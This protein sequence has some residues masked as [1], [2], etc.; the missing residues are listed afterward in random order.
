MS[1]F[2]WTTL[3]YG[4]YSANFVHTWFLASFI[5]KWPLDTRKKW[6][7]LTIK[8]LTWWLL[9]FLFLVKVP[10]F[11]KLEILLGKWKSGLEVNPLD[12]CSTLPKILILLAEVL[13][14]LDSLLLT[15]S[16]LLDFR[17]GFRACLKLPTRFMFSH[18][19]YFWPL[20]RERI[21]YFLCTVEEI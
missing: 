8:K 6:T 18:V 2:G 12:L 17:L 3:Y 11:K 7:R 16:L 15:A 1:D 4:E 9:S 5:K 13:F 19:L 14:I 10:F 21:G 20:E